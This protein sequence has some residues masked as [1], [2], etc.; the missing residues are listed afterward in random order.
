[1]PVGEFFAGQ[2][3]C[4]S[5]AFSPA[6]EFY[7]FASRLSFSPVNSFASRHLFAGQR[8]FRRKTRQ[9]SGKK[10]ADRLA[11]KLP[12]GENSPGEKAADWAKSCRPAKKL[13]LA[14]NPP[15][16]EKA[17]AGKNPAERRKKLPASEKL[18][19]LQTRG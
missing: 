5:A 15:T 6:S 18:P 14:R 1:L 12:N 9:L 2:Q 16:G 7:S 11:K 4:Q 10:P 13:P 17:T 3:F 8:V 19:I